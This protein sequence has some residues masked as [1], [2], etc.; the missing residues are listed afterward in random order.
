MQ[1]TGKGYRAARIPTFKNINTIL[2][3]IKSALVGTYRAVRRKHA[4][5]FLAEFEWRFN[6]RTNLAGHHDALRQRGDPLAFEAHDAFEPD[7][8]GFTVV[9]RLDGGYKWRLARASAPWLTARSMTT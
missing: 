3:N 6:H 9:G 1:V 4:S 8:H 7:P 2:G 5:R